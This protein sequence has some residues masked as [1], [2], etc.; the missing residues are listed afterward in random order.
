MLALCNHISKESCKNICRQCYN[1][2][3]LLQL[4]VS[5]T[6]LRGKCKLQEKML[7]VCLLVQK[8]GKYVA[9]AKFVV[10]FMVSIVGIASKETGA[11]SVGN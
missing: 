10:G 2:Q 5:K 7:H 4:H 9:E 3:V 8:L 6:K 11:A 1:R